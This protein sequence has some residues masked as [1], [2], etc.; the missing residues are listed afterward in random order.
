MIHKAQITIITI[1]IHKTR[2]S[3]IFLI[4]SQLLLDRNLYHFPTKNAISPSIKLSPKLKARTIK[5]A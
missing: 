1:H 4:L 5:L 3:S 2:K